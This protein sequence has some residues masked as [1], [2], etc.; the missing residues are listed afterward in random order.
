L[1]RQLVFIEP[2]LCSHFAQYIIRRIKNN[3]ISHNE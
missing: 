3:V 2:Y 1:K